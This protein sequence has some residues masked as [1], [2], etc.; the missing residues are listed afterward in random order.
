MKMTSTS[1]VVSPIP[2]L[3]IYKI[4]LPLVAPH[5]LI[6]WL[7]EFTSFNKQDYD[8]INPSLKFLSYTKN[9]PTLLNSCDDKTY[10]LTLELRNNELEVGCNCGKNT[11]HLCVHA[12]AALNV[13]LWQ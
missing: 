7:K 1:N 6:D 3:S 13:I 9:I 2:N 10:H 5:Y 11:A 8:W 12:Y 4:N